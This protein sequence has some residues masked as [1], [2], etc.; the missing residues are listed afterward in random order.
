MTA[1]VVIVRL[2]A[3]AA[4]SWLLVAFA[5]PTADPFVVN[6]GWLLAIGV[7]LTVPPSRRVVFR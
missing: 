5:S 4:L 3:L 2:L 1:V 7:V 6:V